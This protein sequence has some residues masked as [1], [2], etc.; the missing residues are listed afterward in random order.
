MGNRQAKDA[1]AETT[2][3]GSSEK[4][5]IQSFVV[6]KNDDDN[7]GEGIP[8]LLTAT[9]SCKL[10]GWTN[11]RRLLTWSD[12]QNNPAI[13]F[14]RCLQAGIST[15]QLHHLQPDAERWVQASKVT[16]QDV[17][18]MLAW[19]LHPVLHFRADISDLVG[20]LSLSLS[21]L[22]GAD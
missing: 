4:Q 17:P 18:H 2:Y 20:F 11:P 22:E 1:L 6:S 14:Q 12:I 8:L 19:P 5:I 13:T 16:M 3:L 7:G 9:Q 10:H 21:L 15:D